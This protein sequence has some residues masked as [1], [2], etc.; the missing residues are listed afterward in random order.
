MKQLIFAIFAIFM[1][2]T[3]AQSQ[4]VIWYKYSES[5]CASQPRI[6]GNT[7]DKNGKYIKSDD[8]QSGCSKYVREDGKYMLF[9]H[10][11][12]GYWWVIYPIADGMHDIHIIGEWN[13]ENCDPA[14]DLPCLFSEDPFDDLNGK[15]FLIASAAPKAE[16]RVLDTDG[17]TLGK[18]G[19][20]VQLWQQDGDHDYM[21]QKWKFIKDPDADT[22]HILSMSDATRGVI[23]LDADSYSF[24][25]NGGKVQLWDRN[26]ADNNQAWKV[27]K[28]SNGTYRITSAAPKAGNRCLDADSYTFN[29]NGGKVL[30]WA[31]HGGPNQQ[32]NLIPVEE[33]TVYKPGDSHPC[34]GIVVSVEEGGEAGLIT[35]YKDLGKYSYAD[36]I[37]VSRDLPGGGWAMP[38]KRHLN[39]MYENLHKK[40]LGNFKNEIYRSGEASTYPSYP[41]SQNFANGKQEGNALNNLTLCRPVKAFPCAVEVNPMQNLALNKTATQSTTAYKSTASN[42]VN[43]V[44]TGKYA[45][46][47]AAEND[48]THTNG[49][50]ANPWWQVDLGAVYDIEA[51]R[52]YN[53]TDCCWERLQDFTIHVSE[54]AISANNKGTQFG[55]ASYSFTK[56]AENHLEVDDDKKGRYV[57]IT[58]N[59]DA[60]AG[61]VLSLSEVEVFGR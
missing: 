24:T 45:A 6:S 42:A 22:Y 25:K 18:N 8:V 57:R 48:I 52:I 17:Y 2:G 32:W 61:N 47:G 23:Y 33:K 9:A 20:K 38:L 19:T 53:R 55:D 36:A 29:R 5:D 27:T 44:T 58:L 3:E 43:G 37:S 46:N 28:N 41:W 40:G 14:G 50:D 54:T 31:P 16:G 7:A 26:D 34:G 35:A 12:F 49:T 60:G 30:L 11:S 10:R 13:T 56:E 1:I 59:K 15:E 21:H 51:I 4:N 39:T